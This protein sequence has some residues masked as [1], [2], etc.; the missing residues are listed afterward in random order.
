MQSVGTRAARPAG[1]M[2]GQG[3][4][5]VSIQQSLL[6]QYFRV[7]GPAGVFLESQAGNALAFRVANVG[8]VFEFHP[9]L[10][11]AIFTA[12]L[13]MTGMSDQSS[14]SSASAMSSARPALALNATDRIHRRHDSQ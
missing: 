2:F 8:A 6:Q 13:A 14:V 1:D 10:R 12:R 5:L 3:V 11:P 4:H 7:L 9:R